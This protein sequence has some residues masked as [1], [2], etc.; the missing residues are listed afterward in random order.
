LGLTENEENTVAKSKGTIKFF[1]TQKGFG[2][3]TP[4]NG[5]KDLFIHVNN[6]QGDPH[7][8][9]EGQLVEYIE[10]AGRKGPE[11]T[12]ASIL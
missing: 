8:L 12:E 1:N 11:A 2:F 5:G 7:S 3:I 4:S 6:F 9:R 10:G